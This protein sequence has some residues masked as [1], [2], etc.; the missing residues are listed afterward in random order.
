MQPRRSRES[1]KDS[2]GLEA[3]AETHAHEFIPRNPSA[4]DHRIIFAPFEIGDGHAQ[5]DS[6]DPIEQHRVGTFTEYGQRLARSL[7][8]FEHVEKFALRVRI[9][10]CVG[11]ARDGQ[12][13]E[14]NSA[15]RRIRALARSIGA[16]E[17][18][19]EP[20]AVQSQP[21]RQAVLEHRLKVALH[22]KE[23]AMAKLDRRDRATSFGLN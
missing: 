22:H 15:I 18:E 21:P 4:G 12:R 1:Q 16:T 7:G 8:A 3:P 10:E 2:R 11:E 13:V 20:F 17:R 6:F 14:T 19:T 5:N 23:R 9:D